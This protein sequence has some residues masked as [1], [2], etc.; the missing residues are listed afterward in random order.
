[1]NISQ[2]FRSLNAIAAI[3]GFAAGLGSLVLTIWSG[4]LPYV[5]CAAVATA[6]GVVTGLVVRGLLKAAVLR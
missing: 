2:G 5:L 4:Y 1:M 6:N 3:V